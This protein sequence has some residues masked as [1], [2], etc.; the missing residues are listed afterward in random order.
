MKR[1]AI[2]KAQFFIF[3]VCAGIISFSANAQKL[4]KVQT[5]SLRAPSNIKIDGKTTE[6][7]N[8][9]QAYNPNNRLYYTIANDDQNLY[10]L[11]QASDGYSSEKALFGIKFTIKLPDKK[12]G[13]VAITFPKQSDMENT[14][15]L[16]N[17]I[18]TVRY[19]KGDTTKAVQKKI[20][21]LQ[22]FANS[23]I[24]ITHKEIVVEGIEAIPD[25]VIAMYNTDGIKVSTQFNSPMRY[26]Y[27][28]A[29]P[30]K[31]LGSMINNGQKFDYNIKML[32]MPE[33]SP[34]GIPNPKIEMVSF[35][36]EA[37]GPG[38]SNAEYFGSNQ[39]F[40]I[41]PTDLS[42]TYTLVKN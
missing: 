34:N 33:V 5:V 35:G 21:S 28:L 14:E 9:F 3:F 26:T 20:D 4:P 19:L 27:E 8:Q 32:A 7:N 22:L 39:G 41:I 25:P 30:L 13:S 36:I 16:R 2:F 10:L 6:W 17:T 29:I 31:Y 42:G 37:S 1:F 24:G 18:S 11:V 15:K 40:V 38:T 23:L 12:N